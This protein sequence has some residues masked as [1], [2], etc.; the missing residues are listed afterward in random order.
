MEHRKSIHVIAEA[1]DP[2]E[3]AVRSAPVSGGEVDQ[4]HGGPGENAETAA[5]RIDDAAPPAWYRVRSQFLVSGLFLFV[6]WGIYYLLS[7]I[8]I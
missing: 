5:D 1:K 6:F 8:H 2:H 4:E 3:E 7:L